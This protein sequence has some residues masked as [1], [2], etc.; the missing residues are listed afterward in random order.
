MSSRRDE[1]LI[2]D[3]LDSAHKILS[4]V[5]ELDLAD[6]LNDSRTQDAVIRNFEIIGEA[7]NRISE[8][9]K[10]KYPDVPWP[11]L[12]GYRNRLIHEYFGVD[13]TIVW[14]I[15]QEDLNE[16]VQQLIHIKSELK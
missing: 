12:R 6:F 8:S 7:S 11:R 3:I 2:I 1:L 13:Y 9:L 16:L 4:Y 15:I 5:E 10:N 14:Q